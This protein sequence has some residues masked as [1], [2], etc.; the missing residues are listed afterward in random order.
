MSALYE[1]ART[2]YGGVGVEELSLKI[3]GTMGSRPVRM[4][5]WLTDPLETRLSATCVPCHVGQ[6]SVQGSLPKKMTVAFRR[7]EVHIAQCHWN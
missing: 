6:T 3:L 4:G 2:L 7:L 1:T 5:A